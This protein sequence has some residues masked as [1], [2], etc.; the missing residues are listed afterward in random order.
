[1]NQTTQ[2]IQA[3]FDR[4]A[5]L[6]GQT[7]DHNAFYHAFLLRQL[8]ARCA[9]ALEI[10]CGTGAFARLLSARAEH[11]LALD[12]SQQM[13]TAAQQQ[14]AA[15]ANI[16]FEVTD[17]RERALPPASFD[18]IVTI[19]TL[20][21]LPF[22]ETVE[23]LKAAL[24][25]GGTLA[26]LDLY[27]QESPAEY[28]LSVLAFP[29]NLALCLLKTGR[30]RPPREVRAAW[31]AHGRTDRYLTLT[32]IQRLCTASLPG[33][34]VRRHLFWRYSLLWRKKE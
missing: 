7:F 15:C 33:A 19:A 27:Q 18:C 24:R 3:D 34:V 22:A 2:S 12:L 29:L 5:L 21:H 17:V 16:T 30:L 28:A 10:G 14:S 8:P 20:H 13:I 31:E 1:M 32:Q 25:V 11:V 4:L 9:A 23:T 26:V 6:E